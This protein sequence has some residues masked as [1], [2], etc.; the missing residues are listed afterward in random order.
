SAD[1]DYMRSLP[2]SHDLPSAGHRR[3]LA[4]H[5]TPVSQFSVVKSDIPYAE[6]GQNIGYLENTYLFCGHTHAPLFYQWES[7]YIV[8]PGSVGSPLDG[9]PHAKYAIATQHATGWHIEFRQVAYDYAAMQR[10]FVTSGMQAFNP[11]LTMGIRHQQSLSRSY[12]SELIGSIRAYARERNASAA[13][14]YDEFPFP[15]EL[16]PYLDG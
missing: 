11:L 15:S 4:T 12:L 14:I 16:L 10:S 8:N 9:T 6:I 13:D 5:A 3:T 7:S 2:L 1:F